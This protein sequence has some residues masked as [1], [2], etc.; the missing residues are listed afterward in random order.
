MSKA[1]IGHNSDMLDELLA[2]DD[3]DHRTLET[4]KTYSLDLEAEQDQSEW[5]LIVTA[6][7]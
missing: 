3:C 6:A 5:A 1:V 4:G 7:N 2:C